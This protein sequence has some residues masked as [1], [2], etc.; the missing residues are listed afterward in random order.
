[1]AMLKIHPSSARLQSPVT[2]LDT[3]SWRVS[4]R[5]NTLSA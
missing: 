2:D 5:L 1:M 4:G 3:P